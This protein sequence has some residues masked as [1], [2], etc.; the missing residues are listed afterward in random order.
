M[1]PTRS[2]G[3]AAVDDGDGEGGRGRG[4]GCVYCAAGRRRRSQPLARGRGA[5]FSRAKR[6]ERD[7][8]SPF[9]SSS[10]SSSSSSVRQLPQQRGV[11]L[12][13]RNRGLWVPPGGRGNDCVQDLALPLGMSFAAVVA[14]VLYGKN[15]TGDRI[16]I[17]CLSMVCTSAVKESITNVYGNKFDCFIRNFDKSFQSTLKTLGLINEVSFNKQE[18]TDCSSFLCNSSENT[19][20]LSSSEPIVTTEDLEENIISNSVNSQLILHGYTNKDLANVNRTT[21]GLGFSQ[22][23]LSTVEKSVIEQTR[24]NDLKAVEIGLVMK[25]LQL[26]EAQLALSSDA[27][28][29]EKFKISMGISKASF[30]E[31]KLRNQMQET[32]NAQLLK[33]CMDLLITG[34]IIMCSLIV[35]GASVYSYQRIT[36]VTSACTSAPKE[37][38]SWWIP[39]TVKSFSSGWLVLKCQFVALA[40]VSFGILMILA[41]AFV[42]F[43][44][45]ATSA[46]TM[47]VTFIVLL[48]GALCGFSG[49]LCID[50]LGGNGY[51]W[52]I[53]WEALCMLHFIVN[54]FPSASYHVLYGP[55]SISEGA[56][57]IKL[58]Y[59]IRRFTF[60]ALLL[61]VLPASGG[62][63][64]FASIYD[65][66]VHFS[67]KLALWTSGIGL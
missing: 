10:S 13:K 46:T 52:L 2:S 28:F 55:V 14:Q 30:K 56:N 37:S 17:D 49:K 29:L 35:Y 64:P 47:P 18:N 39:N 36:E 6:A 23:I 60:Y 5:S 48:L 61:L 16:Q 24:S 22:S 54:V 51:H 41:M 31:A 42:V 1:E 44:R 40:R 63:L 34:L 32:M 57:S 9:S 7:D 43:Q 25:K 27:N 19:A 59:R 12:R 58:P 38:R 3:S 15:I 45:S 11:R 21:Y 50:T 66:K 26:K 67:E 33:I 65:W 4:G 62:L 53:Y 20:D 8:T